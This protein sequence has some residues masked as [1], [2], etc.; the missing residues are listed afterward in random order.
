MTET[1]DKATYHYNLGVQYERNNDS[2]N[3]LREYENSLKADPSFPYPYK[4]IGEILFKSGNLSEALKHMKKALELDPDWI[5]A[6]GVSADIYYEIGDLEKA[7][8]MLERALQ[9]DPGNLHYNSQLGRMLIAE[10]RYDEAINLLN[11]ALK[12]DPDNY[13]FHYHLGVAYGKRGITDIDRSIEHWQN[14]ARLKKNDPAVLKNLS[15]SY[16]T[17]GYM[18]K[19][20]ETFKKVL[21]LDPSDEVAIK[22]LE[23]SE[24]ASKRD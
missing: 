6:L 14:T 10:K 19:A 18:D 13:K 23:F 5:E 21:E 20:T 8:P 16:F 4:S 17:R 3:A 9:G 7:I 1:H 2:D 22:F 11:N 12:M 24:T 15:I